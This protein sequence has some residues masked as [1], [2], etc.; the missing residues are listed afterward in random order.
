MSKRILVASVV[1]SSKVGPRLF[2][3]PLPFSIFLR[4]H[5]DCLRMCLPQP[6]ALRPGFT[7]PTRRTAM[8]INFIKFENGN[9]E[10]TENKAT[11]STL[12]LQLNPSLATVS[13]HQRTVYG[14]SPQVASTLKVAILGEKRTRKL[15]KTT[16]F[17]AFRIIASTQF[18]AKPASRIM[19]VIKP[20]F[21]IHRRNGFIGLAVEVGA[22]M[23]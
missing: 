8:N 23:I 21:H 12:T 22:C 11:I 6:P 4:L 10:I 20:S 19:Q 2:P 18:G 13:W 9:I 14:A 1:L 17:S 7:T 3:Y 15:G 5:H 16:S